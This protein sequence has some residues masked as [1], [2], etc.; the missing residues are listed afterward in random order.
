MVGDALLTTFLIHEVSLR[1]RLLPSDVLGRANAT[2]QVTGGAMLPLGALI[3]G[4]LADVIG[5]SETMWIGA[6]G[7]LSAG[8]ALIGPAVLRLR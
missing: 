7:G 8:L 5:V 1:Q 2:F 3:A 6:V 4:P